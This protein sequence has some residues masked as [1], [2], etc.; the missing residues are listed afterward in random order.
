MSFNAQGDWI[1]DGAEFVVV[2]EWCPQCTPEGVSEP[3]IHQPCT[4]HT[5]STHGAV[6]HVVNQSIYLSGTSEA[7]GEGNTQF[8][9]LIHQ[10][11]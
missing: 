5:P 4:L 9:R 2:R 10:P 3:W 8:C 11:K 6:D 1:D 7:G